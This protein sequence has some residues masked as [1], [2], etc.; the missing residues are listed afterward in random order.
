MGRRWPEHREDFEARFGALEANLLDIDTQLSALFL[1]KGDVP[2][3][4]SHPVY[5][6]FIRRYELNGRSVHWEPDEMP[7][8]NQWSELKAILA[9]HPAGLM[10]WEGEPL[11]E[12]RRGLEALGVRSVVFD[13]CGNVPDLGDFLSVM[14]ENAAGLE[15]AFSLDADAPEGAPAGRP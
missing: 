7:D 8:A 15:K 10:V 14:R 1:G 2:L 5:Q 12:C 4:F 11:E 3:L 9:D 6:Y 13:P